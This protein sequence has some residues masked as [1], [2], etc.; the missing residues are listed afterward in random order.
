MSWPHCKSPSTKWEVT[1]RNMESRSST[2][3]PLPKQHTPYRRGGLAPRFN[4]GTLQEPQPLPPRSKQP[5]C[6]RPAHPFRSVHNST[7]AISVLSG[8]GRAGRR[9]CGEALPRFPFAHLQ[10]AVRG[11]RGCGWLAVGLAH[12]LQRCHEARVWAGRP[13][14]VPSATGRCC[15]RAGRAAHS[16]LCAGTPPGTRA[17][18]PHLKAEDGAAV[19]SRCA[20]LRPDLWPHLGATRAAAFVLPPEER[21]DAAQPQRGANGP[22]RASTHRAHRAHRGAAEGE[23]EADTRRAG[24]PTRHGARPQDPEITT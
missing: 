3:H 16:G 2:W 13:A 14:S 10:R 24:S 18:P 9:P 6:P 19:S 12:P 4:W 5:P 23:G 8:P 1:K 11:P 17:R 22:R 20:T 21:E 15:R 7:G